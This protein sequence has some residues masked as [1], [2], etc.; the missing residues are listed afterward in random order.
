LAAKETLVGLFE[1]CNYDFDPDWQKLIDAY[2]VKVFRNGNIY[3]YN[4]PEGIAKEPYEEM[5]LHI[6]MPTDFQSRRVSVPKCADGEMMMSSA[7]QKLS[8]A[9][10]LSFGTLLL[11]LAA[12][13]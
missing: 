5:T 7:N 11:L 13:E 10:V 2:R 4:G 12:K 9:F 3:A 1:Q 6:C 8:K